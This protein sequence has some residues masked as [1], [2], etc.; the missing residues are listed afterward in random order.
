MIANFAFPYICWAFASLIIVLRV[1]AIWNRNIVVSLIAVGVWLGG[2]VLHIRNLIMVSSLYNP[3]ADTCEILHTRRGLVNAVAMLVIDVV[4]LVSM[5]IGLLRHV[6]SKSGGMWKL[7]YQQCI[8]WLAVALIAEIPP[9]V[10]LSL[11]LN[12]VWNEMLLGPAIAILSIGA[13]R[14]YRSLSDRGSFTEYESSHPVQSLSGPPAMQCK[15]ANVHSHMRFASV[16]VTRSE[17]TRTTF[18]AP[19]FLPADQIVVEFVP[20]GSV[21]SLANE[22]IQ[23][24]ANSIG[25]EAV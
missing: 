3:V 24:K 7:L 17:G 2:L 14:M 23:D 19:V 25:C 9:V 10:F 16:S 11:N 22:N 6:Y 15:V 20:D 1:I 12:D 4:L 8:I 5:L 13:A 18:E 21:S